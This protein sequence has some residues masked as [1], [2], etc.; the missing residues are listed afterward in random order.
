MA[1]R[2]L[3]GLGHLHP[4]G[5]HSSTVKGRS[6]PA[7]RR[8]P[9]SHLVEADRRPGRTGRRSG[10]SGPGLVRTRRGRRPRGHHHGGREVRAHGASAPYPNRSVGRGHRGGANGSPLE[11]PRSAAARTSTR[12]RRLPAGGEPRLRLTVAVDEGERVVEGRPDQHRPAE[13][14]RQILRRWNLGDRDPDHRRD[15][16]VTAVPLSAAQPARSTRTG[17]HQVSSRSAA[18]VDLP[19]FV[20]GLCGSAFRPGSSRR[21]GD[22]RVFR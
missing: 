9:R 10:S 14:L 1:G 7:R 8:S 13:V 6:P 21:L 16:V 19:R 15:R 12:C 5:V 18:L 4:P 20:S 2:Q 11:N 17:G 3:V 22:P